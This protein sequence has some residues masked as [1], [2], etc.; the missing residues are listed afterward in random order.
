MLHYLGQRKLALNIELGQAI[1]SAPEIDHQWLGNSFQ[2][3]RSQTGHVGDPYPQNAAGFRDI[4]GI[5]EAL[6]DVERQIYRITVG[7]FP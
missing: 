6:E 5:R 4:K 1:K 2:L 7:P 3:G